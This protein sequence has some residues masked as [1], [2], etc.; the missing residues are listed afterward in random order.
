MEGWVLASAGEVNVLFNTYIGGCALYAYG[1]DYTET[2]SPDGWGNL[3]FDDGFRPTYAYSTARYVMGLTSTQSSPNYVDAGVMHDVISTTAYYGDYAST[4]VTF[5]KSDTS[6]YRGAWFYRAP[7]VIP[8]E[9]ITDTVIVD[10]VEW[11]QVDLFENVAKFDMGHACPGGACSG[12]LNG[13]NM[14]GWRWAEPNE[15]NVLFDHY[16]SIEQY[17][18]NQQYCAEPPWYRVWLQ[19][20]WRPTKQT[21]TSSR[22]YGFTRQS[23]ADGKVGWSTN[24]AGPVPVTQ[25]YASTIGGI[26]FVTIPGECTDTSVSGVGGWFFRPVAP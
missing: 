13:Y 16:L 23:V 14:D 26:A 25:Y 19:A 1:P 2:P 22:T 24:T 20:G 7:V 6:S 15:V 12:V 17:P 18:C 4:Q 11:A 5:S 9:S 8:G 3:M 21:D 10:G